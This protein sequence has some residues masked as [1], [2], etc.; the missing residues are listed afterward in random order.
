MPKADKPHVRACCQHAGLDEVA[1][2][3]SEPEWS[4]LSSDPAD[5]SKVS[6]HAQ[7]YNIDVRMMASL[8]PWRC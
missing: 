2:A 3:L 8:S 5:L 4:L 1:Q 6:T 7:P